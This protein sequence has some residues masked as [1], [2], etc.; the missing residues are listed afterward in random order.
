MILEKGVN[1]IRM[2]ILSVR[3]QL[4]HILSKTS[5]LSL[6]FFLPNDMIGH[7]YFFS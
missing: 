2:L 5:H 7:R 4:R 3:F 6:L 1:L